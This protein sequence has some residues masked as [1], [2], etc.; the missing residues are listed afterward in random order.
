MSFGYSGIYLEIA[1][2]AVEQRQMLLC[3]P[4]RRDAEGRLWLFGGSD[5]AFEARS[6]VYVTDWV[7]RLRRQP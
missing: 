2:A 3:G 6:I 1:C 4:N 7:V 5:S